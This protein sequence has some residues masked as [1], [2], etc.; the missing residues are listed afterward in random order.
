MTLIATGGTVE[1]A[2]IKL[3]EDVWAAKSLKLYFLM[4]LAGLKGRETTCRSTM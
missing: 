1:A 4:E 3:V 2:A